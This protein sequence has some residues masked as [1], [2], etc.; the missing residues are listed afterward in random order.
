MSVSSLRLYDD[1]WRYCGSF[2]DAAT[3][4]DSGVFP[5]R[6][7]DNNHKKKFETLFTK[8]VPQT[9]ETNTAWVSYVKRSHRYYSEMEESWVEWT[10][11]KRVLRN[12]SSVERELH[13]E[14]HAG[15]M[16]LVDSDDFLY[17]W[18][19]GSY[20][21]TY[22]KIEEKENEKKVFKQFMYSF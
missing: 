15:L 19:E 12:K 13:R 4:R 16:V 6:K 18:M 3:R 17:F 21:H 1:M 10:V 7:I 11:M 9:N 2:L 20:I 22:S 8:T 14:P 5:V